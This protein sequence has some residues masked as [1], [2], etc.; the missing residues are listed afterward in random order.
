[1]KAIYLFN[2]LLFLSCFVFS[3][4]LTTN[5]ASGLFENLFGGPKPSENRTSPYAPPPSTTL[6]K[7]FSLYKD[8]LL[9]ITIQYPSLGWQKNTTTAGVVFIKSNQTVTTTVYTIGVS[10]QNLDPRINTLEQYARTA[11]ASFRPIHGFELVEYNKSATL[12][13]LP[14]HKVT[15]SAPYGSVIYMKTSTYLAMKGSTGYSLSYAVADSDKTR[16]DRAFKAEIPTFQKM[17]NS[18]HIMS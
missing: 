18:F 15:I 14:A 10:V 7:G 17:L 4:S 5:N 11:V 13:G 16:V 1:M 12:A 2:L 9:G 6:E 8:P 3:I